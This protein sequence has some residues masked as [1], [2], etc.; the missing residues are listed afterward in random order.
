MGGVTHDGGHKRATASVLL[1]FCPN[2]FAERQRPC[3]AC[4]I[5]SC[6]VCALLYRRLC[7]L[8]SAVGV[9]WGCCGLCYSQKRSSFLLDR[10]FRSLVFRPMK[11]LQFVCPIILLHLDWF[12]SP[13]DQLIFPAARKVAVGP[14]PR[15]LW[16][17]PVKILKKFLHESFFSLFPP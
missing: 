6:V 12:L 11:L 8:Y 9:H 7:K 16:P 15:R 5:L 1:R 17:A 14:R 3:C 4:G 2:F 10:I 13:I